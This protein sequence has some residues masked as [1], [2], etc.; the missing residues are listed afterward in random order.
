MVALH[1]NCPQL[2][3]GTL[4]L[5]ITHPIHLLGKVAL[6][7][8]CPQHL[9]RRL[10]LKITCPLHIGPDLLSFCTRAKEIAHAKVVKNQ[11]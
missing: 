2:L 11:L 6:D 1:T 4:A 3:R 5:G 8:T 10:A 7:I 9:I